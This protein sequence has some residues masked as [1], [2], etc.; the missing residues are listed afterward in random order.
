MSVSTTNLNHFRIRVS[1]SDQPAP[2]LEVEF[3]GSPA[4]AERRWR[5]AVARYTNGWTRINQHA[6]GFSL[7]SRFR[8]GDQVLTVFLEP[9]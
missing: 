4:I 7:E 9:I 3:D 1:I 2:I 5:D 6:R 8:K